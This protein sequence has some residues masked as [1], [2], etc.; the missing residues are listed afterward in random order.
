MI[1]S[2]YVRTMA[3]YNT[4]MNQRLYAAAGRLSDAERLRQDQAWFSEAAQREAHAMLAAAGQK[5][6]GTDLMLLA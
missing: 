2:A 5:T 3:S 1:S 4:A 6:G